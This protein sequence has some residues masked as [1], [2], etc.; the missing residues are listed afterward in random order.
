MLGLT[1]ATIEFVLRLLQAA[2]AYPTH[3]VFIVVLMAVIEGVEPSSS[4]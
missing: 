4:A 3:S 1:S 2:R